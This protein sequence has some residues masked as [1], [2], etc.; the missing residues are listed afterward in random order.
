MRRLDPC[1]THEVQIWWKQFVLKMTKEQFVKVRQIK[2]IWSLNFES[3]IVLYNQVKLEILSNFFIHRF[4][5]PQAS[6][7]L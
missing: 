5:G 2:A 3:A 4:L 7:H 1:S 6:V